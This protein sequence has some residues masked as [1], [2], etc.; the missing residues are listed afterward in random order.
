MSNIKSQKKTKA[1]VEAGVQKAMEMDEKYQVST[2]VKETAK[3][4][5]DKAME[6]DKQYGVSDKVMAGVTV[7]Q[8]KVSAL[9][10][11]YQVSNTVKTKLAEADEKYEIS[12]KLAEADEQL[13]VSMA[14]KSAKDTVTKAMKKPS[15]KGNGFLG[16]VAVEVKIVEN[17]VS[18]KSEGGEE[19]VELTDETVCSSEETI[20]TL[21]EQCLTFESAEMATAFKDAVVAAKPAPAEN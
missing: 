21:G 13:G 6:M 19:V 20:A 9:D 12:K 14:A 10:E 4:A 15:Y 17:K 3:V 18:L 1:T 5:S 11:Q 7:A 2:K 16:D 8:E